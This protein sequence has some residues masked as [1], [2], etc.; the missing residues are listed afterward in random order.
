MNIKPTDQVLHLSFDDAPFGRADAFCGKFN[1]RELASKNYKEIEVTDLVLP[2]KDKSFDF[3]YATNCL[4]YSKQ[5]DVLLAEIKRV[6]K[7]AHIRERSE[8]AE[9]IFGWDN[10]LWIMDVENKEFIAKSKNAGKIGRFGPYFH[11]LYANDPTF[12]DFVSAN[13]GM[14]NV[15]VDWVDEDDVV[16]DEKELEIQ[17]EIPE[18]ERA[19]MG[20]NAPKTRTVAK[21]IRIVKTVFRP[22]QVE[23]FDDQR[24]VLGSISEKIDVRNLKGKLG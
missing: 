14:M 4:A 21:T 15:S 16:L 17:E 11:H 23:Y 8:F 6:G 24:A 1:K 18:W 22:C 10:T 5:P 7:T 19:E 12:F 13:P 20:E 3:V 9:M 2:Y